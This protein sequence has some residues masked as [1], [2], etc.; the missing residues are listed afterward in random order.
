MAGARDRRLLGHSNRPSGY[1]LQQQSLAR[2]SRTDDRAPRPVVHLWQFCGALC[3]DGLSA[4][5]IRHTPMNA[6]QNT[7]GFTA[8]EF[9]RERLFLVKGDPFVFANWERVLFLHYT[10]PAE[11]VRPHVPAPLE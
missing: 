3:L 1:L 8:D 5:G 9:A 4:P 10:A 7:M 11:L 2:A 6:I